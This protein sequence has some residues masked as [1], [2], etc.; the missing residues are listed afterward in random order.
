M[1]FPAMC[2]HFVATVKDGR[3]HATKQQRKCPSLV[4]LCATSLL[5]Q[6]VIFVPLQ[7]HQLL[8][9]SCGSFSP[10]LHFLERA[11]ISTH[12]S[13][14]LLFVPS[15]IFNLS[16]V[17]NLCNII[18]LSDIFFQTPQS[19]TERHTHTSTSSVFR[20]SICNGLTGLWQEMV[21]DLLAAP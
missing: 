6:T 4:M 14:R 19:K 5:F 20:L 17:Y 2:L 1:Y 18:M 7:Y 9:V 11:S 12:A 13:K 15:S 21:L 8:I 16:C 10:R 3:A